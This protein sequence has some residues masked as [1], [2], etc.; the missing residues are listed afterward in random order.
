VRYRF[1]VTGTVPSRSDILVDGETA[2]LEEAGDAPVTVTLQC[3]TETYVLL[4]YGQL[5][6]EA[7]IATHSVE[8]AGD[9][10]AVLALVQWFKGI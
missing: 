8:V 3:D 7:A 4:I 6:P 10:Q 5:T 9:Q 2:R 1:L